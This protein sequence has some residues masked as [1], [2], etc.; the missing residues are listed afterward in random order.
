MLARPAIAGD[1]NAI[2]VKELRQELRVRGFVWSFVGFHIAMI[3]L[4]LSSFATQD[5][6]DEWA[7]VSDGLF[8][9]VLALPLFITMPL[10]AFTAFTK[11]AQAKELELIFLTRT[12]S[13]QIVFY[14]WFAL[15]L[16]GTLLLTAALPYAIVRYVVG[17]LDVLDAFM[18]LGL[19]LLSAMLL[20]AAA[21]VISAQRV[22]HPR[23]SVFTMIVGL[24]IG[25]PLLNN[26]VM[27]VFLGAL[28]GSRGL[29]PFLGAGAPIVFLIYAVFFLLLLLAFS[30]AHIA[31]QAEN[32]AVPLRLLGVLA[33]GTGLVLHGLGLSQAWV[34][35]VLVGLYLMLICTRALCADPVYVQSIYAPFLQG[36]AWKRPLGLW[37]YP[38]WP[39]GVLYTFSMC[40]LFFATMPSLRNVSRPDMLFGILA[41]AGGL[42]L[43]LVMGNLLWPR[44]RKKWWL[45][46]TIQFLLFGLGTALIRS[47][48]S[49]GCSGFETTDY[50]ASLLPIT[51]FAMSFDSSRFCPVWWLT[52]M[53]LFITFALLAYQWQREWRHVRD[54]V[55]RTRAALEEHPQ[56]A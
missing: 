27:F 49:H 41:M 40:A 13:W 50:I 39:S 8:W 30:A 51:T 16:Q 54:T 38:G 52:G 34:I 32:H 6:H 12:S 15:C 56:H 31:P 45:Y 14:Q 33:L 47:A 53:T 7:M 55:K 23:F 22:Q 17:S 36:H 42:Y 9:S 3:V 26:I 29:R 4:T 18:S 10:R 1:L 19:L 35:E 11:E 2:L 48:S 44:Y 37:L 24:F 43:P 28:S 46:V 25:L 5:T 20:T 21:L